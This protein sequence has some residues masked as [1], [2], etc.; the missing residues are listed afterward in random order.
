M[1]QYV[2]LCNSESTRAYELECVCVCVCA[3]ICACAMFTLAGASWS[4]LP[5]QPSTL[6]C[7]AVMSVLRDT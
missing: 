7:I 6:V 1:H 2:S 5:T 4:I 3:M